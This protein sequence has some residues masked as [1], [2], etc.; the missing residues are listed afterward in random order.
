MAIDARRK[1]GSEIE[2]IR[3]KMTCSFKGLQKT[4]NVFL[5]LEN[6]AVQ[7][8]VVDLMNYKSKR[9]AYVVLLFTGVFSEKWSK[10]GV[11]YS[12]MAKFVLPI[13]IR[14]KPGIIGRVSSYDGKDG[15]NP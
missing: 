12:R 14:E 1:I 15:S 6:H 4:K 11:F 3:V 2:P 8:C 10:L 13:I 9:F 5:W 7:Y